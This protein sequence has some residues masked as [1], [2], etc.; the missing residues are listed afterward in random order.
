MPRGWVCFSARLAYA[1][2]SNS[3]FKGWLND[4]CS[5]LRLLLQNARHHVFDS[6][7]LAC[8]TSAGAGISWLSGDGHLNGVLDPI[9]STLKPFFNFE[10]PVAFKKSRR[11]RFQFAPF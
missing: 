6:C 11:F 8:S 1:F 10:I 4:N 2:K 9:D 7:L 5:L 3:T